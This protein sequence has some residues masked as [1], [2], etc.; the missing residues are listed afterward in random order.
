MKNC[1]CKKC[2]TPF[3]PR[4]G[5]R[6]IYCGPVCG[7]ASRERHG[8]SE[9]PEYQ[10]W[11]NMRS[12]CLRK[13]DP[14]FPRYGGRGIQI[15]ERWVLFENFLADMGQRPAKLTIERIDNNGHYEPS[16]C[17][18]ATQKEQNNNRSNCRHVHDATPQPLQ[19]HREGGK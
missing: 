1:I 2:A 13:S 5:R 4:P 17:K 19:H 14:A 10:V 3:Q 11:V 18:W 12:R 9:T 7:R 8:L 15:C 6:G 16:N